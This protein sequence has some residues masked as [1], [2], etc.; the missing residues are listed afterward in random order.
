LGVIVNVNLEGSQATEPTVL[1]PIIKGSE[2]VIIL[3]DHFQLPPT[4][5]SDRAQ[6]GGLSISLFERLITEGVEPNLLSIQYR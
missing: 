2:H 6:K 1:G 4:V 3:G 5:T